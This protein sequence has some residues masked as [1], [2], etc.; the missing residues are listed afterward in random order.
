MKHFLLVILSLVALNSGLSQIGVTRSPEINISNE[1]WE[2]ISPA[3][4]SLL[5]QLERGQLDSNL[6]AASDRQVLMELQGSFLKH[7]I[8]KDAASGISMSKQMVNHYPIDLDVH[9][10]SVAYLQTKSDM[11][12]LRYLIN[13]IAVIDKEHVQFNL[14]LTWRTSHWK[15][16]KVGSIT[17][18]HREPLRMDRAE[19][20]NQLNAEI[21]RKFSIKAE[22]FEFYMT[23]NYQEILEL[24]GIGYTIHENGKVRNGLG[25]V[26]NKIFAI[27]HNEDFSH[28]IF[29]YYSGKVNERKNRNWIAEEGIAYLWGN[30]YYTDIDGEMINQDRLEKAL[31]LYIDENPDAVLY[32]LFTENKK[33]FEALAPEVSVRSTI[34]GVFAREVEHRFGIE[35]IQ[36]LINCGSKDRLQSFMH[37]LDHLLD[38]TTDNF[39]ERLKALLEL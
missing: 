30:A 35:G 25:V 4:D 37:V 18:I 27:Q 23:K 36:Q 5:S 9:F 11:P 32:E 7:E 16:T 19:Y 13:M 21:A 38:V 10:I 26:D 6:V 3:I 34:A 14:P 24:F 12:A 29:H 31:C 33:I 15:R 39:D 17:Y 8:E 1:T 22:P 2:K 20:F 28:D